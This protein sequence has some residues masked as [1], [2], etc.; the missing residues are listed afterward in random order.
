METIRETDKGVILPVK[1]TPKSSQECI[2]GWQESYL[3]IKVRAAPEKGQANRA[4]IRL[5]SKMLEVPQAHIILI[6]GETSR[7]KD[8][9]I[10]DTLKIDMLNKLKNFI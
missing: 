9:L 4:V 3:R 6:R 5:L 1:V 8:F 7:K 10:Q 2:V